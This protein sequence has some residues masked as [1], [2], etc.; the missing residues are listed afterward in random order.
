MAIVVVLALGMSYYYNGVL[1]PVRARNLSK[2]QP[3]GNWS[4][5]YP[6]WLG[7]RELLLR[8]RNPYSDEVTADIQRGFYAC[9]LDTLKRPFDQERFAYPA[10][11]AFLFAPFLKFPFNA[12][13]SG[14]VVAMALMTAVSVPLWLSAFQLH[15]SRRS[16]VVGIMAAVSSFPALEGLH[17]QQMTLVVAAIIAVAMA[18]LARGHLLAAGALLAV[19]SIK[20][21]LVV[22]LGAFLLLWTVSR[23]G[24]RKSF[25]IGLGAGLLALAGGAEVVLPGWFG[26]W[27][28]GLSRY[29]GYVRP[30]LFGSVFGHGE[31]V[32]GAVAIAGAA[33]VFWRARRREAGSPEFS[34]AIAVALLVPTFLI[35]NI[36]NGKYDYV[37]LIPAAVWLFGPGLALRRRSMTAALTWALAVNAILWEWLAATAVCFFVVVLGQQ[38]SRETTLAG[39]GPEVVVF[40]L[41]FA[42]V[43]FL[44]V[45]AAHL[46]AA[47]PAR[48]P[49]MAE[50]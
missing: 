22:L 44:V 6:R 12:V 50:R 33:W 1:V 3:Q 36:A 24:S 9:A 26:M 18:A 29:L 45:G 31:W 8:G 46:F 37:L 39:A 4:D 16:L 27:R 10:Y 28:D 23:W 14:F 11:A 21:Q 35:R 40:F 17:L 2:C 41:P 43:P 38:V 20:P 47:R 48:T 30:S 32:A 42:L 7:S 15:W 5:L 34:L 19:A 25:A 49:S 13:R